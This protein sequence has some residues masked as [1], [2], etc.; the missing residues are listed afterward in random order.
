MLKY[1]RYDVTY[2]QLFKDDINKRLKEQKLEVLN[3]YKSTKEIATF[4][5]LICGKEFKTKYDFVRAWKFP[6][7]DE[8]RK[9]FLLKSNSELYIIVEKF[10]E[11]NL[12]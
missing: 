11:K 6:G 10:V 7:C 12:E 4:R 9:K 2:N 1:W 8:C 5:C 3:D